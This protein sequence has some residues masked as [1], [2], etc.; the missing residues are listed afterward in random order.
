MLDDAPDSPI[1]PTAAQLESHGA[2][3]SSS[4]QPQEESNSNGDSRSGKTDHGPPGSMW[5]SKKFLEEYDNAVQKM[6]HQD[7]DPGMLR[8]DDLG[9]NGTDSCI[10]KYGDPLM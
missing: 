6:C 10:A 3:T 5:Q 4:R 1:E 9:W 8:T 2:N 7:F